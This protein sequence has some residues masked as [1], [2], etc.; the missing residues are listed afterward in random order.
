MN[1]LLS[2]DFS[3]TTNSSKHYVKIHFSGFNSLSI[4]HH[5]LSVPPFMLSLLLFDIFCM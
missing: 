2:E 5:P 4:L 3:S 1:Y